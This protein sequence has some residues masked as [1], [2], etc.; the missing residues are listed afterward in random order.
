[1]V[2]IKLPKLRQRDIAMIV[3]ALTVL[4][5]G[6][7]W[8][9]L[10]Q[11]A[12]ARVAQLEAEIERLDREIARGEAAR[13]NLP[14]LRLAVD[15]AERDRLAFLAELPRESEVAELLDELRFSAEAA[16][17]RLDSISQGSAQIEAV[18]G[19]R[20]LGFTVNTSGVYADTLN[21]LANL[22]TLQRFAKIR[23]VSLS[24]QSD[25]SSNPNL[26]A[27]YTFTVYVFTGSD[28]GAPR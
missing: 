20:P 5:A 28:P 26:N 17:V 25:D 15:A 1:M 27:S 23:Q 9:Y 11:P 10:Y 22:E 8:Y 13:R 24:L 12:Q 7:W 19:V 3:M 2:A 21:F 18:Q 14:E 6:L 4:A 16:G